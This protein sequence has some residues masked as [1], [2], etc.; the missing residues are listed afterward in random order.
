MTTEQTD[1][2][3]WRS[4]DGLWTIER[5]TLTSDTG[6]T[7]RDYRLVNEREYTLWDTRTISG[8]DFF[9]RYVQE[10]VARHAQ[11]QTP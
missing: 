4:A 10:A 7:C 8:N 11:D 2:V 3:V 1:A 6:E 9:P 5:T